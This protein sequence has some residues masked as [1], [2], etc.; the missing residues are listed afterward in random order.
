M[1]LIEWMPMILALCA[2]AIIWVYFKKIEKEESKQHL[3][4]HST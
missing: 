3:T 2:G 1:T 4:N